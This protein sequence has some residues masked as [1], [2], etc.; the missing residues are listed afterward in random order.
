MMKAKIG[1]PRSEKSQ[2]AVIKATHELLHEQGGAGLTIEAIARRANV[3]KPTI[4]R[5][6][7]TLADIVLEAVLL[8]AATKIMVIHFESLQ[9]TLSQFLK[10][11]MK[12][13]TDGDGA[14]LRFL[15]AH[16]QK[17]EDFRKRFRDNFTAQRRTVLRS[18]FLQ[19][20]ERGRISPEQ[21]LEMLIDIVFGTMWYRLLIG[22]APMDESFADELTEVVIK[23]VQVSP[24]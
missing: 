18:I 13:I 1:R 7:P 8:Q 9:K 23:L 22:H 10:Q 3:G 21:N 5:W 17:D 2:E 24:A 12:T 15:M 4:Y 20:M 14:H 19:A 6:W 16:A 11:S